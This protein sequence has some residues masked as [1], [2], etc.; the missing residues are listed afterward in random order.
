MIFKQQ[1][2]IAVVGG[3]FVVIAAIVG[4]S[5]I[6]HNYS[7]SNT[8]NIHINPENTEENK[9]EI[10]P[11][12][13]PNIQSIDIVEGF[14]PLSL[15]GW[16][17]WSPQADI[18]TREVTGNECIVSSRGVI[19]D[20]AGIVNEHLGNTL[21]GRTLRLYFSNTKESD[22]DEGRMIKVE[23]DNRII[24]PNNALPREG[25][26]PV[27]DTPANRGIEYIFPDD[28]NGKLNFV[29]YKADL[30]NFKITAWYR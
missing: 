14:I 13:N 27:E 12:D 26:L 28:F 10:P 29:F 21:R 11:V 25:F 30:N 5:K 4:I 2:I 17:L 6:I 22:F 9:T 24:Q 19:P 7:Q 20:T 8:I 16:Y 23:F 18:L 3:L 1:L 15:V